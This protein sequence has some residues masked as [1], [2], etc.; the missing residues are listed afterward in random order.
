MEMNLDITYTRIQAADER[1][2]EIVEELS[3]LPEMEYC[4]KGQRL[5]TKGLNQ[6][7][8]WS[9]NFIINQCDAILESNQYQNSGEDVDFRIQL[10]KFK[11]NWETKLS[12]IP[13]L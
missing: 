10:V 5:Q 8:L 7:F 12:K 1:C 2:W 3:A 6:E 13:H 4:D 9:A 11:E